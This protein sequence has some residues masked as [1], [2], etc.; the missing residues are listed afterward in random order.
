MD[1][2]HALWMWVGSVLGGFTNWWNTL[3]IGNLSEAWAAAG[4]LAVVV[5]TVTL[6]RHENRRHRRSELEGRLD[7]IEAGQ[8]E[9]YERIEAVTLVLEGPDE[10]GWVDLAVYNKS[11]RPISRA[12][13]VQSSP[14]LDLADVP[15]D[16]LVSAE[17]AFW[18]GVVAA[19]EAFEETFSEEEVGLSVDDGVAML[20]D[21][22]DGS[23]WWVHADGG[24][25]LAFD[26][27]LH[28]P[29]EVRRLKRELENLDP[30]RVRFQRWRER[31]ATNRRAR[32]ALAE[33]KRNGYL[34]PDWK[35]GDPA[36]RVIPDGPPDR[37]SPQ[38]TPPA[39]PA[40]DPPADRPDRGAAS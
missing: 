39:P 10:Y 37:V 9:R 7:R 30:R 34:P 18:V 2:W 40:T 6:T 11:A 21:D 5:V 25:Q 31:R 32:R 20:F 3:N 13:L 1:W 12:Y 35:I 16:R 24:R 8:R 15:K 23:T 19:G 17:S 29:A 27:S 38:P 22:V 14:D 28:R 36:P 4:S 26:L 33:L